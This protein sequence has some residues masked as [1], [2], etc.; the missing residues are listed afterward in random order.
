MSRSLTRCAHENVVIGTVASADFAPPLLRLAASAVQLGFACVIV[1]PMDDFQALADTRVLALPLPPAPLLPEPQWCRYPD[2]HK[3]YGWRRSQFYKVRMWMRILRA[4]HRLDLL[5]MDCDWR[6]S[7]NPVPLLRQAI[8][9]PASSSGYALKHKLITPGVTRS[10]PAK[11]DTARK[12]QPAEVVAMHDGSAMRLLNIG[13]IFLRN[14]V[15]VR[16]MVARVSNRTWLGW[17]Q[18]MLNEE[19]NFN[20]HDHGDV[21]CC[22]THCLRYIAEKRTAKGAGKDRQLCKPDT[23][24]GPTGRRLDKTPAGSS[25]HGSCHPRPTATQC[26]QRVYGSGVGPPPSTRYKWQTRTCFRCARNATPGWQEDNYNMLPKTRLR[27]GRCTAMANV[28]RNW[29]CT[30]F[31]AGLDSGQRGERS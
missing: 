18:L 21:G 5:A 2:L 6:I 4:P 20:T 9:C 17:D 14:T 1:Q 24:A 31:R 26:E 12:C 19:V 13:L 27:D 11:Q 8:A 16:S 29:N 3:T 25:A 15:R 10:S 7:V 28:C 30:R 22:H 23:S